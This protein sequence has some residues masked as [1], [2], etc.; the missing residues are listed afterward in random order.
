MMNTLPVAPATALAVVLAGVFVATSVAAAPAVSFPAP[1]RPVASIVSPI[2]ADEDSRDSAGEVA[3]VVQALGIGKGQAVADIG[4]GSGYYV[5]RLAPIVGPGGLVYAQDIDADYQATLKTRV[6]KARLTNVRFVL[7]TGDDPRLPAGSV[8]VALLVHM[9]HEI[10]QP[11]GLLWR[12]RAALKPGGRIGIVDLDRSTDRH[13]TP[14]RLLVCEAGA[15][16]YDLVSVTDLK[17]G[18]LAIFRPGA[19]VQPDK[20]RACRL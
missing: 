18:Y 5:T 4:A 6:Q 13:G 1:A 14:R 2:W 10:E 12:L 3:A 9:Y 7:G 16:G 17:P 11:F 19:S 20:V 8:D 15:V